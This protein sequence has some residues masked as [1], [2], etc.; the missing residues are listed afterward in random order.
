MH[1]TLRA[2]LAV[3]SLAVILSGCG[4]SGPVTPALPEAPTTYCGDWPA[5]HPPDNVDDLQVAYLVG[6]SVYRDCKQAVQEWED[7]YSALSK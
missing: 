7:F 2:T 4:M 1:C 3:A 5:D 6:E